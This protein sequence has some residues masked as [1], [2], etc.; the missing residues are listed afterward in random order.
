MKHKLDKATIEL[1]LDDKY[2]VYFNGEPVIRLNPNL[3]QQQGITDE[4]LEKL[5]RLH[6]DRIQT[7][8][9]MSN[10]DD[11]KKLKALFAEW[12]DINYYLQKCWGFPQDRNYH[13]FWEVPKCLCA[14]LDNSDAYPYRQYI[15]GDCPVH[16]EP[17]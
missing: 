2:V 14:K 10:T 11:P 9:F 1:P 6:Q 12:T 5:K 13:R 15:S 4:G 17:Q 3:V 7:E 16:G 8:Q